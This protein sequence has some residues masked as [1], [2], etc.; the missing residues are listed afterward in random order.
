M[1]LTIGCMVNGAAYNP[2]KDC[3]FAVVHCVEGKQYSFPDT[4]AALEIYQR[5]EEGKKIYDE[6]SV[7]A[8]LRVVL[9][10]DHLLFGSGESLFSFPLSMAKEKEQDVLLGRLLLTI[11][12][13]VL[14]GPWFAYAMTFS[15]INGFGPVSRGHNPKLTLQ[16]V[17]FVFSVGVNTCC[18]DETY[19]EVHMDDVADADDTLFIVSKLGDVATAAAMGPVIFADRDSEAYSELVAFD[20]TFLNGIVDLRKYLQEK[21]KCDLTALFIAG[22]KNQLVMPDLITNSRLRLLYR[23]VHAVMYSARAV[24]NE[25]IKVSSIRVIGRSCTSGSPDD[26]SVLVVDPG[27]YLSSMFSGDDAIPVAETTVPDRVGDVVLQS[28][29]DRLTWFSRSLSSVRNEAD[30]YCALQLFPDCYHD[31]IREHLGSL[32]NTERIRKIAEVYY[33]YDDYPV[34][35]LTHKT[36]DGDDFVVHVQRE[37]PQHSDYE[38]MEARDVPDYVDRL[39]RDY[40]VDIES[41]AYERQCEFT[42]ELPLLKSTKDIIESYV[43]LYFAGKR[44]ILTLNSMVGSEHDLPEK[45]SGKKRFLLKR[46]YLERLR[47]LQSDFA[48]LAYFFD[49]SV[50]NVEDELLRGV[51]FEDVA[52]F[53]TEMYLGNEEQIY[54]SSEID[55][56]EVEED[57][58]AINYVYSLHFISDLYDGFT[59]V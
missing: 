10:E 7:D 51:S 52:E 43:Y 32:E 55:C 50:Y 54:V 26:S 12:P 58:I 46:S 34:F 24:G 18:I 49:K 27:Q 20:Y 45:F 38:R 57:G 30:G 56:D 23:I 53:L 21:F 59:P 4:D 11:D 1:S 19:P 5:S 6:Y 35:V 28:T 29:E 31:E 37:A 8:G 39:V 42:G 14:T 9:Y 13:S 33:Y 17:N 41:C 44:D 40:V 47:V 16:S 25:V 2:H 22:L 3:S 15:I 36:S 48:A